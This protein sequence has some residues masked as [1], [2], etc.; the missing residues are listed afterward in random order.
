MRIP[1]WGGEGWGS[2][3]TGSPSTEGL[4]DFALLPASGCY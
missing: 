3:E 1:T 2:V 4:L